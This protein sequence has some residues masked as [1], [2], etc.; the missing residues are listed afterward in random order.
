MSPSRRDRQG[1]ALTVL[2]FVLVL[3]AA[4]RDYLIGRA[5]PIYDADGFFAPFYMF[6]A[7]LTR[8]GQL[9]TWNPFNNAGSPDFADPQ[10]GAF[11]P[12]LLL[13]GWV[14]GSH[15]FG[16]LVYWLAMWSAAG[17]GI[18]LLARRLGCALPLALVL[19][20]GF[21]FSGF[22]LGHAEHTSFVR[23]LAFL[24]PT[25]WRLDVAL[26]ERRPRA[27]LES[28]VLWGLSGLGGYPAI[29][30]LNFLAALAWTAGRLFCLEPDPDSTVDGAGPRERLHWPG[31]STLRS[32]VVLL[33]LLAGTGALVLL[34][35]YL[36][37]IVEAAEYTSR[38]GGLTREAAVESNALHPL[39]LSTFASP[40]LAVLPKQK[41][42]SYT[43]MSSCDVYVGA[44][45]LMLALFA[46]VVRP[47]SAWRWAL[48][49][50][51][52]FAL[53][54]ALSRVLPL[55]GWLYDWVPPTRLFRHASAC[56]GYAIFFVV[57]LAIAGARDL[58]GA[59]REVPSRTRSW[60]VAAV[61][62]ALAAGLAWLAVARFDAVTAL[63]RATVPAAA[64]QH[65]YALW[66]GAPP[67][68][69]AAWLLRQRPMAR[70]VP[71]AVL[72]GLA[73]TD[74]FLCIGFSHPIMRNPPER[75]A[76]LWRE[77]ERSELRSFDLLQ[78][79]GTERGHISNASSGFGPGFSSKNLLRR[80]PVFRAYDT[81]TNPI[82]LE[83]DE[84]PRAWGPLVE[85]ERFYFSDRVGKGSAE[86]PLDLQ[87][88]L[89]RSK[90]LDLPP[91][92]IDGE[93]EAAFEAS[94]IVEL[95]AA[96]RVETTLR[97][98]T[99]R[100]LA[101]DVTAPR[102]GWLLVTDRWARSWKA[103]VD[104]V[105]TKIWKGNFLFRAVQVHAGKNSVEFTYRP[106]GFPWL[107]Y[108]SWLVIA[109]VLV[110]PALSW[111][112]A[113]VRTGRQAPVIPPDGRP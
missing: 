10:V 25:L 96:V 82:H 63:A 5:F 69:G 70:L 24:G 97:E 59:R 94:P 22:F 81:L 33:V 104:D 30:F 19:A 84:D 80:Q 106:S 35:T 12:I 6:L 50:A 55:R 74:A 26:V 58:L 83:L 68:I 91:I 13:F 103:R 85:K 109:S 40:Y 56:R 53:C 32:G 95:P 16:F 9:L 87:A 102:D 37:T 111:C 88:F 36:G 8:A 43:D 42:W 45:A 48:L 47:R 110:W 4:N 57:V 49:A 61:F 71:I 75:V 79:H 41:L 39:A 60:S 99:M 54:T 107:T 52:A 3:L 100:T 78:G 101:F 113:R 34:P 62:L 77:L 72:L 7:D 108:L 38:S 27:A 73:I 46:L 89:R 90:R 21:A 20:L 66:L 44:P 112:S 15:V 2:A 23:S 18:V 65:L 28:G 29:L 67:C 105:P 51:A 64:R 93:G 92:V 11:D 76:D 1:I 98:Y 14:T 86:R 17:A 31:A